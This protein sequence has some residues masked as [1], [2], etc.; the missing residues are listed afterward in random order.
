LSI[1]TVKFDAATA[2]GGVDTIGSFQDAG[3]SHDKIDISDI[4]DGH[5]NPATDV[6]TNF[7]QLVMNGSN[8]EAYVDTTGTA[9]FNSAD[10][11]ATITYNTGAPDL[12]TKPR[13]LRRA[14]WWSLRPTLPGGL[15]GGA[16]VPPF[17]FQIWG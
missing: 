14:C 6:I 1:R 10:H 8:T 9:A 17:L 11:I 13:S 12:P 2:F 15:K 5:Y 4:L 3:A 16:R 7:V